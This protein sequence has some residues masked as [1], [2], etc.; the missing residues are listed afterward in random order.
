[1]RRE[2]PVQ[3]RLVPHQVHH[4]ADVGTRQHN[5]DVSVLEQVVPGCLQVRSQGGVRLARVGELVQD[6]DHGLLADQLGGRLEDVLPGI[7]A[8]HGLAVGVRPAPHGAREP[9]AYLGWGIPIGHPVNVRPAG[10]LR[11]MQEQGRLAHPPAAIDQDKLRSSLGE[12]AVELIQLAAA[13]D[14]FGHEKPFLSRLL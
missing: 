6:Q 3:G 9:Q 5:R 11:P 10:L 12:D 4:H 2:A 1:M 7:E 14:E 13:P 8:R